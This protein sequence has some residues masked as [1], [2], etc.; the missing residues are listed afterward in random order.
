MARFVEDDNEVEFEVEHQELNEEFPSEGEVTDSSDQSSEEDTQSQTG[1]Q[2]DDLLKRFGPGGN[3][4]VKLV[5]NR[6]ES[7]L[8]HYLDCNNNA[9]NLNSAGTA[10]NDDGSECGNDETIRGQYDH[11][12]ERIRQLEQEL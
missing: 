6:T 11:Y 10:T 5:H 2:P 7:H 1:M 9:T 8:K 4:K 12:K 3:S